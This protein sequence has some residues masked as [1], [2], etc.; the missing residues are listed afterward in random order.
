MSRD[1]TVPLSDG[2][3]TILEM[4]RPLSD[5]REFIFPSHIELNR[6]MDSQTV[7]A[8]PKYAGLGGVSVS[9]GLRSA[10]STTPDEEGFPPGVIEATPAH[11]DK[12]GARRV[13]N[14]SDYLEQHRPMMQWWTDLV[15]AVDSGN[16]VLI[17]LSRIRP[18]G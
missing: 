5:G 11:I 12:N 14:R 15:K 18:V 10:V 4:M 7:N 3:P 13:Y 9:H 16:I 17:H 6:P 1:H 8:A 2:A